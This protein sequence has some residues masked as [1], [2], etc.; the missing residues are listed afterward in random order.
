MKIIL[1][2]GFALA[3]LVAG[4]AIAADIV[5]KA[6]VRAAPAVAPVDNWAGFYVGG[7]VGNGWGEKDWSNP[8][9][10]PSSRRPDHVNGFIAGGQFGFNWQTGPWVFGGEAQASWANLD[11]GHHY[12][13]TD[14]YFFSKVD[15][16]GTLAGRIGY[17]WNRSMFYAKG[18]AGWAYDRH[19]IYDGPTGALLGAAR[20][21]RWGWMAGA[22]WEYALSGPW[23]AKIEYNYMDFGNKRL[24]FSGGSLGVFPGDIDQQ[25]HVVKAGI[26]YRFGEPVVARY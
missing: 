19:W 21:T 3:A 17:G 5:T 2:P 13:P 23:S 24:T 18:G 15:S 14:V 10:D 25:I 8:E 1:L 22:G 20:E 6:P 16:L 9:A 12:V 26:N 7:H 4:P 11:G